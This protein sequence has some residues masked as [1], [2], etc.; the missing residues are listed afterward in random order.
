MGWNTLEQGYK[1][2][3]I[4]IDC[5]HKRITLI[6]FEKFFEM[7][8]EFSNVSRS[9]TFVY[10]TKITAATWYIIN[11]IS[12]YIALHQSVGCAVG[13]FGE[14][15]MSLP[16]EAQEKGKYEKNESRFGENHPVCSKAAST[17]AVCIKQPP[18]AS[19]QCS[20]PLL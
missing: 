11:I 9:E 17:K 20:A 14:N 1:N 3:Y 12:V 4:L 15:L 2:R 18:T 19:M 5:G 10:F 13:Q 7:F 6:C 16:F 8:S